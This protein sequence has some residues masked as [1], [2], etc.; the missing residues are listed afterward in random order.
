MTPSP[1]TVTT[2]ALAEAPRLAPRTPPPCLPSTAAGVASALAAMILDATRRN[3]RVEGRDL[4]GSANARRAPR[5][6]VAARSAGRR[7]S[8]PPMAASLVISFFL[9][10]PFFQSARQRAARHY[11]PFAAE[12]LAETPRVCF[13]S[14]LCGVLGAAS[15]PRAAAWFSGSQQRDREGRSARAPGAGRENQ[16]VLD[17]PRDRETPA[18]T[19]VDTTP[20]ASTPATARGDNRGNCARSGPRVDRVIRSILRSP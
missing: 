11:F 1:C 15:R 5:V 2:A 20:R 7:T 13:L 19:V 16:G 18:A 4:E 6:L 9:V 8:L 10:F 12:R 14:Y 3:D 17:A